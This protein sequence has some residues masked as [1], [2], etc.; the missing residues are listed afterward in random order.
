VIPF[1]VPA[2]SHTACGFT[3]LRAPAPLRGKGFRAVR[4]GR[5][6]P[7]QSVGNAVLREETERPINPKQLRSCD[8]VLRRDQIDFLVGTGQAKNMIP[9]S[10]RG[11]TRRVGKV[12]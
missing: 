5:G 1:P 4:V 11:N 6:G 10:S 2:A 7:T 8:D 3:A 12:N 9:H